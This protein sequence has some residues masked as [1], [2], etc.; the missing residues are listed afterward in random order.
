MHVSNLTYWKHRLQSIFQK[1]NSNV[2]TVIIFYD[3]KSWDIVGIPKAS[4][5]SAEKARGAA[6]IISSGSS[7]NSLHTSYAN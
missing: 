3:N 4:H 7:G 1:N 6:N 2:L 5:L